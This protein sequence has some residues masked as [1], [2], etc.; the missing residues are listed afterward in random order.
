VLVVETAIGETAMEDADEPVPEG[1]E[2]R[3]VGVASLP[4]GVVASR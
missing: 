1:S 2:R 3:M 4:V